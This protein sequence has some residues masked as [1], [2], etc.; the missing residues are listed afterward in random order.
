MKGHANISITLNT[1]SHVLPTTQE[2]LARNFNT[3]VQNI[4]KIALVC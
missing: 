2:N 3:A 4:K 1:Y